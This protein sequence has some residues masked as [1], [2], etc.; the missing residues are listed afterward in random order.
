MKDLLRALIKLIFDW[1]FN[2]FF[3][4]QDN[5]FVKRKSATSDIESSLKVLRFTETV[6][7][8]SQQ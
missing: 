2:S 8:Y 1:F 4:Q 3:F 7:L 6:S 5:I